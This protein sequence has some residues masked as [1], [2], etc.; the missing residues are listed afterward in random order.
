METEEIKY[1]SGSAFNGNSV[2]ANRVINRIKT[3]ERTNFVSLAN[4]CDGNFITRRIGYTLIKRKFLIGQKLKGK[5]WVCANPECLEEL[6]NYIGLE[7]LL[8]DADNGLL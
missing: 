6:L 8:F 4:W 1:I 7:Q 2:Q 5:W 3:R